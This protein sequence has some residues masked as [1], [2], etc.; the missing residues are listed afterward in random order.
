M[1]YASYKTN[2]GEIT[3]HLFDSYADYL[4]ELGMA[5]PVAIVDFKAKGT[6]YAQKKDS[7]RQ[8][9]VEFQHSECGGMYMSEYA[10]VSKWFRIMGKRYGL[11][12]E[13]ENE[14]VI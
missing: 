1:F 14:G 2:D 10:H 4:E 6:T 5:T 8:V 7:V 3:G 9:A 11:S 13:F 12:E